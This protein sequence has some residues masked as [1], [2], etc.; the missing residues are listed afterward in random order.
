MGSELFLI[1]A[2]VG[3]TAIMIAE[4]IYLML[5]SSQDMRIPTH[6]WIRRQVVV[7]MQE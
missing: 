2:A 3:L 1:Y 5:S 6:F 4:A 7:V